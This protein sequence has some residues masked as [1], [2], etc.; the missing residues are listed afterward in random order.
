MTFNE[1]NAVEAF[2]RD[3]LTGKSGPTTI[4]PS[5]AQQAGAITGLSWHFV[6]PA[7]LLRQSQETNF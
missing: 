2:M 5:L 1:A 4:T 7:N 6:G 3:R